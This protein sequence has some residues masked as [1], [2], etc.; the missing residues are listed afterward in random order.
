[1]VKNLPP[2]VRTRLLLAAPMFTELTL[3]TTPPLTISAFPVAVPLPM[4]RALT[5]FQSPPALMVTVL[6]LPPLPT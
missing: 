5:P 2:L 1:M 6:L 4:V 3:V